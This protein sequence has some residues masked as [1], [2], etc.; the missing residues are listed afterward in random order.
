MSS[1]GD[2]PGEFY[3]NHPPLQGQ[4][5]S[6]SCTIPRL[7]RTIAMQQ[8]NLPLRKGNFDSPGAEFRQQANTYIRPDVLTATLRVFDPESELE[9]HAA[10]GQAEDLR[11]RFR[12]P[13]YARVPDR[14]LHQQL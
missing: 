4:G 8:P 10:V 11:G 5:K 14:D 2:G 13:Q 3:A 6:Q 1:F 7:L 9:F 12:L